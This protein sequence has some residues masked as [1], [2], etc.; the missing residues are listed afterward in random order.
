MFFTSFHIDFWHSLVNKL[1]QM[2]AWGRG[3]IVHWPWQ[4]TI[5]W[6]RCGR[7]TRCTHKMHFFEGGS[8]GFMSASMD[9]IPHLCYYKRKNI[10]SWPTISARLG[11]EC[12]FVCLGHNLM[13]ISNCWSL[14]WALFVNASIRGGSPVLNLSALPY[15]MC[16]QA[17]SWEDHTGKPSTHVL[18]SSMW[19]FF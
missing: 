7:L 11:I 15:P 14:L 18:T 10:M 19:T 9:K 6:E 2:G 17:A 4:A 12:E 13:I 8:S 16:T 1:L 5:R 3:S